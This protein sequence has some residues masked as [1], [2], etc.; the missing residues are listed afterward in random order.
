MKPSWRVFWIGS[1]VLLL[2]L[3][4]LPLAA[5]DFFEN[6]QDGLQ[7]AREDRPVFRT[8]RQG[9]TNSEEKAFWSQTPSGSYDC[10]GGP[11]GCAF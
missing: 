10:T 9:L 5:S 6:P 2:G 1:T 3:S 11:G 4:V 8:C 7:P